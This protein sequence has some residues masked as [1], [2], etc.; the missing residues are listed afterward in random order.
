M[1]IAERRMRAEIEA[2]PNGVYAFED[3][4]ED[5]GIS[6]RAYPMRASR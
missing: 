4:I 1:A 5:D 6:D 2:I 3:A